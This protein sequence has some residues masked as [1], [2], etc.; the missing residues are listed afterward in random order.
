MSQQRLRPSNMLFPTTE[1]VHSSYFW[2]ILKL[3][4]ANEPAMASPSVTLPPPLVH[5]QIKTTKITLQTSAS[6]N[7]AACIHH[8]N[9]RRSGGP[10]NIVS[11]I[12]LSSPRRPWPTSR[13][14]RAR[15]RF[16]EYIPGLSIL[17]K[18]RTQAAQI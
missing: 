1:S 18:S 13:G 6:Q 11:Y 12:L 4:H 14:R 17:D 10:V 16:Q 7:S 5:A 15:T 3:Q 9:M 2:S 8:Q